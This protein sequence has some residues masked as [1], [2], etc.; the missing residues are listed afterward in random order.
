MGS[1]I[2]RR[3]A[4]MLVMLV[5][6]CA[7]VFV[8]FYIFPATP[9]QSIC[10]QGCTPNSISS[11]NHTLGLD[12]PLYVQFGSYLKGI[13]AGQTYGTP[14]HE[15]HCSLPCLGF[16]FQ[17]NAT[18]TSLLVDRFA[19]SASIAI[20]AAVLFLVS[21]VLIGTIAAICRGTRLDRW[22]MA[23]S[24]AASASPN[25]LTAIALLFLFSAELHVL[26]YPHYTPLASSPILW[27]QGLLLPWITLALASAAH[28]ARY[29]RGSMAEAMSQDYLRTA[30]AKGA[31]SV[32]L[33]TKHGMR[34]G[35][36][37]VMTMFGIQLAGLLGGT[38][39]V[40]TVFGLP[41]LGQ[42]FTQAVNTSD[43]PVVMGVTL[44]T[45]VLVLV[46]NLAVDLLYA[47]M[48]PCSRT[49]R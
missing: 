43:I 2:L 4:A 37:P 35:L 33:V 42:L 45:A 29:T 49:V 18:V 31:G 38:I 25:F 26:P 1:Y 27:F 36:T 10:G 8:I 40:E 41:G 28:Y 13:F 12:R 47:V 20:G 34:G 14:P 22:L 9:A 16:S 11:I 19:V 44:L 30:R 46:A 7:I 39:I 48:D 24:I 15:L 5:V 23:A 3:V 6:I 17:S 32:R 21:G